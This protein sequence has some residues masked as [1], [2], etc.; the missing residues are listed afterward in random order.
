MSELDD[1]LAACAAAA[2]DDAPRLVWADA[3]GGERGELVV[4][5]CKLAREDVPPA[6]AGAMIA[7]VDELLAAH[8]H[9]WSGFAETPAVT[10]CAFR[11]GFVESVEA[12]IVEMPL[13]ALLAAAPLL[14]ALELKG[15]D[16]IVEY[17]NGVSRLGPDPIAVLA[18][19]FAHPARAQ[20]QAIG[21]R[22][23]GIFE[24]T[25]DSEWDRE[26]TSR[27]DEACELIASS[28]QLRG[29]RAFALRDAFGPR[30]AHELLSSNMLA[31]IERLA[32]DV[33]TMD[34]SQA[35]ELVTAM[36]SLRA[37]D[38]GN[39]AIA[40]GDIIDVL[41]PSF[42]EL[43]G[44]ILHDADVFEQFEATI[45][46]QIERLATGF[47]R[48]YDR[49][50]RLRCLDVST[51]AISGPRQGDPNYERVPAFARCSLPMLRELRVFA[52]LSRDELMLIAE[53]F[54]PQLACLELTAHAAT[55]DLRALVAGHIRTGLYHRSG[56]LLE[57]NTNTREPGLSYGVVLHA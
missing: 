7:R 19:L 10:R 9:A 24:Y 50:T 22:D 51:T 11:R 52:D 53:A 25:G 41:P 34:R 36:P 21:I 56:P 3:I 14:T 49:F 46:P 13:P 37:L 23:A 17:R 31:T 57:T 27:G 5:Q 55:S 16:Q 33:G 39:Q 12:N 20:L 54:G 35:R 26:W 44:G 40:L 48:R 4:L 18:D 29:L 47:A 43:R 15:I 28:G 32:F 30:G 6:E 45:A 42:V 1:L 38:L 2:D 8:G